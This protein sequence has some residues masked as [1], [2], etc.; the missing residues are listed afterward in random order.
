MGNR[1][2]T[3]H[4]KGQFKIFLKSLYTN[5]IESLLSSVCFFWPILNFQ[6]GATHF[7]SSN[8]LGCYREKPICEP[9]MNGACIL[10]ASLH[11]F[12]WFSVYLTSIWLKSDLYLRYRIED[13]I[14]SNYW[15]CSTELCMNFEVCILCHDFDQ[16]GS[17]F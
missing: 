14:T 10:F 9:C 13:L 7:L 16:Y 3:R 2:I 8:R 6:V 15:S 11:A 4:W 17:L 12:K 5:Q 1:Y